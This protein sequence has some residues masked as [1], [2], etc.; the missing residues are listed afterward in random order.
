MLIFLH[1]EEPKRAED[2]QTAPLRTR[3]GE[4]VWKYDLHNGD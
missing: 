3:L 4:A 2:L 1:E